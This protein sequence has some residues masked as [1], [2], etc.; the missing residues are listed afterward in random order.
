MKRIKE[1]RNR[2]FGARAFFR[3]PLL[4]VFVLAVLVPCVALSFLAL[5]AADRESAYVERRLEVSLMAEVDSVARGAGEAI[6]LIASGLERDAESFWGEFEDRGEIF[7]PCAASFLRGWWAGSGLIGV[8]FFIER[9]ELTILDGAEQDRI[10]NYGRNFL[11]ESFGAFLTGEARLPV[12]EGLARIYRRDAGELENLAGDEASYGSRHSGAVSASLAPGKPDVP[13]SPEKLGE[14]FEP[15]KEAD[16]AE[17]AMKTSALAVKNDGMKQQIAETLIASDPG[18]REDAFRQASD[19]GFEI[20]TRN[21]SPTSPAARSAGAPPEDWRSGTVAMSRSFREMKAESNWGL[22]P[23]LSENGLALLFWSKR[24]D[25]AG[26]KVVGCSLRMDAVKSTIAGALGGLISDARVL[27]LLDERGRPVVPAEPALT[28]LA[29][30]QLDW[31]RPFAA[32]EIS[33]ALPRWEVGAW[34]MDPGAFESRARLT[35]IAVWVM[36]AV[37]L[38]VIAL[39]GAAVIRMLSSE[40]LTASQRTTFAANVSH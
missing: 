4:T 10:G 14:Q 7:A 31:R 36:V 19:E 20:M 25:S 15:E 28:A 2:I 37:L 33:P 18:A 27:V 16:R 29:A 35:R 30:T 11:T 8:P 12:Y 5:R 26:E 23:Y 39:G 1:T 9:G 21:V 6:E 34:L 17:N 3:A 13:G 22:L 24:E 40:L 32:R 38:A